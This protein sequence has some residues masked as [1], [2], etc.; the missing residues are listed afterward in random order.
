MSELAVLGG[1]PIRSEPW[2]RWPVWGNAEWL[3]LEQV[4][5]SGEWG[6]FNQL[7]HS[8][9]RPSRRAAAAPL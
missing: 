1:K 2:P 4:L 7:V 5:V 8:S 6:G 9:S 3:R